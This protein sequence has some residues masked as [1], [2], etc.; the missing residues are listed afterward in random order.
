MG[1][2][3]SALSN[4]D[5]SKAYD[6][7]DPSEEALKT[8]SFRDQV[9]ERSW[10]DADRQETRWFELLRDGV[11]RVLRRKELTEFHR[12]EVLMHLVPFCLS[13]HQLAM[14]W[15]ALGRDENGSLVLDAGHGP[16]A[17]RELARQHLNQCSGA[18]TAALMHRAGEMGYEELGTGRTAWRDGPRTFFTATM[19]AVGAV[20]APTGRRFLAVR[21]ALLETLVAAFVDG[22][23]PFST[24]T[25][26]ILC[27]RLGLVTDYPSAQAA[28]GFDLDRADLDEN[29]RHLG[30]RLA[31]LGLLQEYSDATKMVGIVQ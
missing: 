17:V 10:A 20:N 14:A 8:A 12:V 26:D 3:A 25:R 19:Y 31:G 5:D 2:I 6:W 16:G 23:I 30:T 1:R 18:I 13:M 7:S 27:G 21:P 22:H 28:G 4:L 24:F 29:R 9:E 15:R 11:S